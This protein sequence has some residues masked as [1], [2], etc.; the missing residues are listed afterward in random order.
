M[1]RLLLLQLQCQYNYFKALLVTV[2]H[3]DDECFDFQPCSLDSH[4]NC[5]L[6]FYVLVEVTRTTSIFLV[7]KPSPIELMSSFA[8]PPPP[9][10]I[11][12]NQQLMIMTIQQ[13]LFT[14]LIVYHVE[15]LTTSTNCSNRNMPALGTTTSWNNQT[16][17]KCPK[18]STYHE[19]LGN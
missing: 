11:H 2:H 16:R 8:A 1:R 4:L 13:P 18:H 14:V 9:R 19:Y 12:A 10:H 7:A 5:G 3:C 17:Q 15:V 6:Y